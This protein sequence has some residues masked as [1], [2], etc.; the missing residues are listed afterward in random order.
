MNKRLMVK[1][2][3]SIDNVAILVY[4]S[5]TATADPG[6]KRFAVHPDEFAAQ[7]DYLSGKGYRI[8]TSSEMVARRVSAE[9]FADPTV[10]LTFDD[11]F[12]DFYSTVL[13]IL[14]RHGFR[15]TLYVPTGYVGG[16]ARWLAG[17]GEENRK[18]LTW[19][20]LQEITGEAIE[21]ASHSHTHAQ[22]DRLPDAEVY[23]EMYRSRC[24]LEDHLGRSVT[25]FAYPFGYWNRMVRAAVEAA[26]YGYACEV[27][28]V[29]TNPS[30][31]VNT[32]PRLSVNAGIGVSGLAHLL[33]AYPTETRRRLMTAKRLGWRTL[34]RVH[35]IDSDPREGW[36]GGEDSLDDG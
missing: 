13:P 25:G 10:V 8:M 1:Q 29:M 5:V 11:A 17:C 3:T 21:I 24:L 31:N 22:L 35:A 14:V 27:G 12:T 9:R 4:H 16:T 23:E 15:A 34:R 19:Q 30:D 6:F 32:L 2:A 7:M 33:D 18:V 20:A 28:E 36:N 26:G